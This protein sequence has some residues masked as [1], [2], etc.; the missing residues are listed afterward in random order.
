[1]A[2]K[3]LGHIGEDGKV[4]EIAGAIDAEWWIKIV[5]GSQ[6]IILTPEESKDLYE[7][8]KAVFE[9]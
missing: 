3:A 7:A 2:A 4:Y 5:D 9:Q 8:M 6:T 1:V